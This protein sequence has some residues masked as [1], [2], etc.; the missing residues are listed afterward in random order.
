MDAANWNLMAPATARRPLLGA[1][2][3][4][5]VVAVALVAPGIAF[6]AGA[7]S[8][9]S[10]LPEATEN[11]MAT[12]RYDAASVL[13]PD[14][15]VLIAGGEK[16]ASVALASAELFNPASDVFTALGAEQSMHTEREGAAAA[17]LPN[18]HALVAIR[19]R[20]YCHCFVA[21]S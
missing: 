6:G 18:G 15:L 8:Y 21:W 7:S 20:H 11:A 14:D 19:R 10:Q 1:A 9:F 5:V 16:K 12:P 13:L 4:G 17:V 2:T 3:A